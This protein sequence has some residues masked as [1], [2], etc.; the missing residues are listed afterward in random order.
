M[1]WGRLEPA[2]L[3]N[4]NI[5]VPNPI[6]VLDSTPK[7]SPVQLLCYRPI[8]VSGYNIPTDEFGIII[9][10]ADENVIL[11]GSV[12]K[13]LVDPCDYATMKLYPS[14]SL[15]IES[16]RARM[17]RDIET[18]GAAREAQ[19][20]RRKRMLLGYQGRP[21][22]PHTGWGSPFGQA[23]LRHLRHLEDEPSSNPLNRMNKEELEVFAQSEDEDIC[24]PW[25]H[26][27]LD[28]WKPL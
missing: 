17:L 15:L 23:A 3:A 11:D 6:Q 22:M 4:T 25:E 10:P 2:I 8:L 26:D 5:L 20:R 14:E 13:S 27:P 19:E 9:G 7:H 12:S 24:L 1:R 21:P 18:N 28:G 16:R